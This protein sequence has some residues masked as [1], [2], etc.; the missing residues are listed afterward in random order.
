MFK[1]IFKNLSFQ[2]LGKSEP[3]FYFGDRGD[4][5]YI[6]LEGDLKVLIPK[7]KEE[8]E[9]LY[10]IAPEDRNISREDLKFLESFDTKRKP[11]FRNRVPIYE[12]KPFSLGRFAS[13][14]EIALSYT[15]KRTATIV[16]SKQ[17]YLLS[18]SKRAFTEVCEKASETTAI[19]LKFLKESFPGLDNN[20][21]AN[22][23]CLLKEKKFPLGT[24]LAEAGKIPDSCFIIKSGRVNVRTYKNS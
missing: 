8:I 12:I 11:N 23:L 24:K 5:F 15:N 22:L 17:S 2:E 7:T 14:G 21:L 10:K 4:K 3:L 9:A 19:F 20:C 6:V 18:L 13:F 16:A 1:N